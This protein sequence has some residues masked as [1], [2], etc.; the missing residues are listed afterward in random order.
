MLYSELQQVVSEITVVQKMDL[1]MHTKWD[2][3]GEHQKEASKKKHTSNTIVPLLISKQ[4]VNKEGVRCCSY[5]SSWNKKNLP[6]MLLFRFYMSI[7]AVFFYPGFK[8]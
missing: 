3:V 2:A 7:K 8:V 1:L 6:G 4:E 5:M